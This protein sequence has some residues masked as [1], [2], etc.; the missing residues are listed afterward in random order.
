MT[1]CHGVC[2]QLQRG[3]RQPGRSI[4]SHRVSWWHADSGGREQIAPAVL[5]AHCA[6]CCLATTGARDNS[7]ARRHSRAMDYLNPLASAPQICKA[8]KQ[9]LTE[10]VQDVNQVHDWH[11]VRGTCLGWLLDRR[12]VLAGSCHSGPAA[13]M[14]NFPAP[15]PSS[16]CHELR[17]ARH[18]KGGG[19]GSLGTR[20]ARRARRARRLPHSSTHV[21]LNP[22]SLHW[23]RR[24][25]ADDAA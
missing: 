16:T 12:H 22:G 14:T 4:V 5:R 20:R 6:A 18:R 25:A 1:S 10:M 21:A 11:T 7:C 19:S 9:L 23:Q 3:G 24:Q 15:T 2:I 13:V 17:A 8:K